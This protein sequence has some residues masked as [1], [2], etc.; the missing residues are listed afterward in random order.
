MAQCPKVDSMT[1]SSHHIY[2]P[3]I[4]THSSHACRLTCLQLICVF[5]NTN[6]LSLVVENDFDTEIL[7]SFEKIVCTF[8]IIKIKLING[9]HK[10]CFSYLYTI[11][12]ML[13][14]IKAWRCLSIVFPN[15][16][17]DLYIIMK[18]PLSRMAYVPMYVPMYVCIP[19]AHSLGPWE[20]HGVGSKHKA[21][22]SEATENASAKPEGAKLLRMRAQSAKPV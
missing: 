5:I 13:P 8:F 15:K 10:T 19:L 18:G 22:G 7:L 1:I 11:C 4:L 14:Q 17:K 3:Q 16:T 12:K 2:S 9:S 21:R 20:C 6:S